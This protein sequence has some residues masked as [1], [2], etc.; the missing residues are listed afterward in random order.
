L[1]FDVAHR[2]RRLLFVIVGILVFGS[3]IG[4]TKLDIS[5]DNR[6]FYGPKNP[7]FS[8]YLQFEAEFSS[9]DNVLFVLTGPHTVL[10]HTFPS[11]IRWLS[12]RVAQLEGVIRVDSLSTYPHPT[13]DEGELVVSSLLDWACPIDRTECIRDISSELRKRHLV[14]RLVS[15][16]QKST[17]ILA[18]LLIER[19][20]VGEV[21]RIHRETNAIKEEF[22][23][24][25]GQFEINL[26]GGVP[27]MAA[28]AEATARDLR[29]LLPLALLAITFLLYLILGSAALTAL[30]VSI[31]L[32]SI[33]ITLGL[34]GFFG[35]TLNNATS[36]VPLIIFTLVVAS[37]MH[38]AVHFTRN[39]DNQISGAHA[40]AQARGSLSSTAVPITISAVTSAVSLGSMWLADSP[41]LRQLGVL[42]AAG[43][44][45]GAGLTLTVLPILLS[46]IRRGADTRL[47]GLI[48]SIL[49]AYAKRLERGKHVAG[50]FT[51]IF[52]IATLGFYDLELNDD[53][54][55]F[56][57]ESVPFRIQT[58]RTTELLAGPN[59][60]EVIAKNSGGSV[61]DLAFV[62]YVTDLS[63]L[64]RESPLVANVL[65]FSDVLDEV[66][67]A[68]SDEPA[69]SAESPEELAQLFFIY[70]LSLPAGQSNTDFVNAVQDSARISILLNGSTSLQIQGLERDIQRWG[71]NPDHNFSIS[72]TGENIPVAHLTRMNIEAMATGIIF[73]LSFSGLC[74]G[75][76]FR[77][78]KLGLVALISTTLP[79]IAGFGVW[80]WVVPDIGLASTGIIAL[81]IGIVVDD[82]AHYI[83]R[84]TDARDRLE[85]GAWGAAAYA[86]HRT[87]SAIVSTTIVLVLGLSLLFFSSFE[88]NSS[89]GA[90]ACL[91]ITTAVIFNLAVLPRLA[92]WASNNTN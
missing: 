69:S 54:V 68:F 41:P 86:T 56:F 91:I 65:S 20:A 1:L 4:L 28:F 60:I 18:T 34:A 64:I 7:Y 36:I 51:L 32:G 81:T 11:A 73:S 89:F 53:F 71:E 3:L 48:Q 66:S 30:I 67:I 9:N 76:V 85:L 16:D 40:L 78:L 82:A 5:A 44:A 62:R 49:N 52:L 33:I 26:T 75:I 80:A 57:D 21:E 83:Y 10:E 35:H 74:L 92:V 46:K 24:H 22:S 25:Y 77:S 43:V 12:S 31:G 63:A 59:H 45:V 23:A 90:V 50:F 29:L 72:V 2:F 58:D 47:S 19:G 27:M 84:F 8:D 13:T 15:E 37:S 17:G 87:G 79:V 55:K 70:E 88:V 38:I 39:L 42:S 61:F 14:N 6:V